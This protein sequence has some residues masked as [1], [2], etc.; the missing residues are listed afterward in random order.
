[1]PEQGTRFLFCARACAKMSLIAIASASLAVLALIP[2]AFA[3]DKAVSDADVEKAI[4]S[5]K[6]E[7]RLKG[8]EEIRRGRARV[9]EAKLRAAHQAEKDPF[10]RLRFLQ[11]LSALGATQ[12]PETMIDALRRDESPA[13][14]QAAAQ[15]LGKYAQREDAVTALSAAL[16]TDAAPEVRYACALSLGLSRSA[17]ALA[18]LAKAARHSDPQLRRQ[19]AFSLKRHGGPQ[20]AK[21]LKGLEKDEDS[22]VREM[23]RAQ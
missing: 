16:D 23:A 6:S 10:L 17:P 7:Q 21:I 3:G 1:M 15:E 19:A 4:S 20:A 13:V 11:G 8:L 22:S 2:A 9:S 18:A 12:A 14:R 5:R